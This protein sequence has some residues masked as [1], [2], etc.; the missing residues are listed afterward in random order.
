MSQSGARGLPGR[1]AALPSGGRLRP[2]TAIAVATPLI[3]LVALV[4]QA[5]ADTQADVVVRPAAEQPLTSSDLLCPS[6]DK[7]PVRIASAAD[8]GATGEVTTRVASGARAPLA[9]GPGAV[10]SLETP[11]GLLVHGEDDMAAGLFGARVGTGRP[12][13]WECTAPGGVRWFVGAGSGASHLSTLVLANPDGGPAVA[14]VTVWSIDGQLQQIQSR[15]LTIAGGAVSTLALESLAPDAHELAVRVVASRGRLSASMRDEHA[16]VGEKL[17]SDGLAAG[18]APARV[19]VMPGLT[20]KAGSRVLTLVNPGR[21]EARV[22]VTIAGARSTF[23]PTT[24]DEIVVPAGRVVTADLTAAL[25][26]LTGAEDVGL[27]LTSTEPVAA[28]LRSRVAGDLVHNPALS[29]LAGPA[30]AIVPA[31]GQAVL[32]LTAGAEDARVTVRW[33]AGPES[34]V[35]LTAGTSLLVAA[36][37]GATRVQIDASAP[38]AALARAQSAQGVAVLPLRRLVTR[39]LVPSVRPEWP[40]R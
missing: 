1:R 22:H 29:L 36:P 8:A 12:A 10:V 31:Q 39:L 34:S 16:P 35:D 33:D 15:G 6:S 27:V 26:D 28:G 24:I 2:A 14:D 11:D 13:A 23:A 4:A 32:A 21:D 18:A 30:A 17:R 40:P 3:T 38:V 25:A 5:P 20:R 37:A 19:Q 7:G 9:L